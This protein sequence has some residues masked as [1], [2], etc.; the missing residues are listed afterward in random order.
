M[1]LNELLELDCKLKYKNIE[2]AR[3]HYFKKDLSDKS[4]KGLKD[5]ITLYNKLSG[6]GYFWSTPNK[7]SPVGVKNKMKKGASMDMILS[8]LGVEKQETK[9]GYSSGTNGMSDMCGL[10][11]M[12]LNKKIPNPITVSLEIKIPGDTQKPD[13]I[14]FEQTIKDNGGIYVIVTDFKNY[15][16]TMDKIIN[17]YISNGLTMNDR[18]NDFIRTINS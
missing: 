11:N 10:I 1:T 6:L 2:P 12:R 9:Y 13:Q 4:E 14:K 5:C 15:V 17:Y 3:R 18:Y 7:S 16:D 8:G